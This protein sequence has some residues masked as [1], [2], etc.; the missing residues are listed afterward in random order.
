MNDCWF[1]ER[2]PSTGPAETPPTGD[3]KLKLEFSVYTPDVESVIGVELVLYPKTNVE[4]LVFP[5]HCSPV[6]ESLIS[7]NE[8]SDPE[9]FKK[10]TEKFPPRV[11]LDK[12]PSA[13]SVLLDDEP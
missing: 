8:I 5:R 13:R 1:W 7:E 9:L 4:L 2:L 12:K 6:K 3:V 11:P 10:T